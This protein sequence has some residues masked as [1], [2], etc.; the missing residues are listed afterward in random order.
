MKNIK[1][2][3]HYEKLQSLLK[4]IRLDKGILQI[5]LADR[6]NVPQSFISKYEI[7]DRRLD[8]LELRLVCKAIGISLEEFIHKLEESLDETK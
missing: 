1:Q 3:D 7:G 6:L 8:I 2:N 4:R 5:D